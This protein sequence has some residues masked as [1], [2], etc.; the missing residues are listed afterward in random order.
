[1]KIYL[2]IFIL[3]MSTGCGVIE[4][5]QCG[6]AGVR[7]CDGFLCLHNIC[8]GEPLTPN[9]IKHGVK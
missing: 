9:E 8:H 1:M 5:I 2:L 3:L 7:S 6:D 4:F